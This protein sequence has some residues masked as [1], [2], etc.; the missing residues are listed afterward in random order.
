M[1]FALGTSIFAE[2]KTADKFVANIAQCR[3]ALKLAQELSEP[4]FIHESEILLAYTQVLQS[5]WELSQ[6]M[7]GDEVLREGP[8][9]PPRDGSVRFGEDEYYLACRARS[10]SASSARPT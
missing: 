2:F 3:E 10:P 5:V 8:G 7:R 4:Q 6:I 1:K 9:R